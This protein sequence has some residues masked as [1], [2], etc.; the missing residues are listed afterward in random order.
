MDKKKKIAQDYLAKHPDAAKVYLKTG[1]KSWYSSEVTT[2]FFVNGEEPV[3]FYEGMSQGILLLPGRN[4]LDVA[5]GSTRPG[6][7]HKNV[8]TQVEP[9][10]QEVEAEP[11]KS[12]TLGFNFK[13][14][15][16]VFE[17]KAA[18]A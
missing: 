14:E 13:E 2:V 9:S 15:H 6:I 12:Y 16:Y 18:K 8:T 7:L 5:A 4:V 11:G 10:K 3:H 17:E 1:M